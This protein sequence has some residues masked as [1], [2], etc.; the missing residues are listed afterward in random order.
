MARYVA[1]KCCATDRGP[2]V[3]ASSASVQ[4]RSC[5]LGALM[6][7]GL[8]GFLFCDVRGQPVK[9]GTTGSFGEVV[10]VVVVGAGGF[11]SID[12]NTNVASRVPSS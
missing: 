4:G 6:P 2:F 8:G 1:G 9:T 11:G 5:W 3:E 12:C 7:P 10:V